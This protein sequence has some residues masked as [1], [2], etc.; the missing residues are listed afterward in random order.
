MKCLLC[1]Y[2]KT[3]KGCETPGCFESIWMTPE[4][5]ATRLREAEEQTERER[6][7]KIRNGCYG[8]SR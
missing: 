1:G 8:G 5:R 7:N 6:I 4:V 3:D 2:P